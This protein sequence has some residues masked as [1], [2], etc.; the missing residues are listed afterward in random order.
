MYA[1]IYIGSERPVGLLDAV[2]EHPDEYI[3]I[4]REVHH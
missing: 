1:Y 2:V 3:R 4:L